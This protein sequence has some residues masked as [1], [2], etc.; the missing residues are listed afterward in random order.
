MTT[1]PDGTQ[2]EV[3]GPADAPVVVQPHPDSTTETMIH[4]MDSARQAGV[5]G[6][7]LRLQT[8]TALSVTIF[9]DTAA[10]ARRAKPQAYLFFQGNWQACLTTAGLIAL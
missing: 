7:S 10:P 5:Y 1:A 9:T 8:P 3:T 6:R 2:F 4:V